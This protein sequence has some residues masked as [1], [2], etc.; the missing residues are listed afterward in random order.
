MTHAESAK[1]KAAICRQ[2]M[3]GDSYQEIAEQ[4]GLNFDYVRQIAR[5]AGLTMP[6]GRP[7]LYW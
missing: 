3:D 4:Y 1:R 2:I 7:R 6:A 5:G